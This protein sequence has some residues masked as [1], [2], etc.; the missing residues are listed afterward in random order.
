MEFK[1]IYGQKVKVVDIP[2][3]E[4]E[5]RHYFIIQVRLQNLV[6]SLYETPQPKSCYS[7]RDYV[8]RKMKWSDF[9]EI[10]TLRDYKNA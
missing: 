2:V 10:F 7:F 8:K 4:I 6:S 1:N 5:D 9:E 3:L